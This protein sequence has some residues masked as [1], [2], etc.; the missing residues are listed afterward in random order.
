MAVYKVKNKKVTQVAGNNAGGGSGG[1]GLDVEI[2]SIAGKNNDYIKSVDYVNNKLTFEY[3]SHDD[4]LS[5]TSENAVQ[6]KVVTKALS[7]IKRTLLWS[8]PNPSS[9]FNAQTITLSSDDYDFLMI[10][11]LG[12]SSSNKYPITF[13]DKGKNGYIEYS[14]TSENSDAP[15]YTIMTQMRI[16]T[17]VDNKTLTISKNHYGRISVYEG[18]RQDLNKPYQIYGI[19]LGG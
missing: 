3:G 11:I 5:N 4:E 18:T 17:F 8:N 2:T 7:K 1:S 10:V 12:S 6:N 15:A 9:D 14:T 13:L 19:K 16:V